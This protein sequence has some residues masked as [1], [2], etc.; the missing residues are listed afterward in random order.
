MESCSKNSFPLPQLE[1]QCV[2]WVE[3]ERG[4]RDE[5]DRNRVRGMKTRDNLGM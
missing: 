5:E 3:E 2:K 4:E 1:I